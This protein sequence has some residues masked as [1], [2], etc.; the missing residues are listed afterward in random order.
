ME[1]PDGFLPPPKPLL[2]ILSC[3]LPCGRYLERP[4]PSPI[5]R[6]RSDSCCPPQS[7]TTIR[8]AGGP[9]SRQ[10]KA[11]RSVHANRPTAAKS[12]HKCNQRGVKR[13]LQRNL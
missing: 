3:G 2:S 1:I 5:A 11:A 13:I 10:A 12:P 6:G 7:G 9:T 4:S 8:D